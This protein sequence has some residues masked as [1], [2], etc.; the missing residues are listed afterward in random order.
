MNP[1]HAEQSVVHSDHS[2]PTQWLWQ[3][4]LAA[5]EVAMDAEEI[6][7]HNPNAEDAQFFDVYPGEHYRL[8]RGLCRVRNI[9]E[10]VEIGTFTGMGAYTLSQEDVKVDTFDIVAW[11]RFRQSQLSHDLIDSGRVT[12]HIS[13]LSDPQQFEKH[14]KILEDAD[15][16][17]LDGPKDGKFEYALWPLL[18]TLK[19]RHGRLLLVDDIRLMPMIQ[20]WNDIEYPKMDMTSLG[21][22]SGTGLVDLQNL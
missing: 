22:W 19:R 16:I 12:Q 11:D 14:R 13:D 20:F 1:R 9:H 7:L 18:K 5:A 2:R 10:A 8:L 17:F 6:P 21:H 15:L 4:A 3:L